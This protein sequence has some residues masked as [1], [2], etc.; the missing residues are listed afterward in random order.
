MD[1][2]IT[3]ID[4]KNVDIPFFLKFA[5]EELNKHIS[6]VKHRDYKKIAFTPSNTNNFKKFFEEIIPLMFFL[7]REKGTYSKIK[8]MSG[9]QKGDAILDS[10]ITIEITKAQHEKR[11]VVMQDMLNHGHA[12]SP[13]NKGN[14]TLTSSPTKTQPYVRRN[15]EH[16]RDVASYIH[17]AIEK[18]L[19]NN[20][21][22]G[23]ILIVSFESDTLMLDCDGDYSRLENQIMNFEKGIFSKIYIIENFLND[24]L[25]PKW[26]FML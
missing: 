22:H 20:Y 16:I 5:H 1:I 15:G 11:F 18:K 3:P 17:K 21:P 7:E 10:S 12:F 9:D 26:Q 8:Y 13:K 14:T 24:N 2:D 25:Q 6:L 4:E 23:S 19:K